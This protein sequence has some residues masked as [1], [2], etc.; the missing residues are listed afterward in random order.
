[1]EGPACPSI[2][3]N[4]MALTSAKNLY[5]FRRKRDKLIDDEIFGE[6]CWDMLLDLYEANKQGK[7]ISIS[8]ACIA[9]SVPSTTALRWMNVLIQRG[10][11]ERFDDPK[12]ARRSF[13]QLTASTHAKMISLFEG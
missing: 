13:V 1:M 10:H 7:A 8:S 2:D 11:I 6:P 9:A 4:T 12:D 3:N 5:G